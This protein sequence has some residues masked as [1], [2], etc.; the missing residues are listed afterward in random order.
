LNS[1]EIQSRLQI[2]IDAM[3]FETAGALR[4]LL[5]EI[6]KKEKK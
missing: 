4:D 3:D 1:L 2:A 5:I 6:E